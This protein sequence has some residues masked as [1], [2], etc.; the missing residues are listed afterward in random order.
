MQAY[1]IKHRT[2]VKVLDDN[3]QIPPASAPVI[4]GDVVTIYRLDGMYCNGVNSNGDRIYIAGWTEVEC[5]DTENY[6]DE[7]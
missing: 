5:L 2:K 7:K 3:V 1:Q 4:K 6:L